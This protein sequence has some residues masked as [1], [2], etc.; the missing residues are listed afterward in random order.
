M[1]II[2]STSSRAGRGLESSL[3]TNRR[4]PEC[5]RGLL[6]IK[7]AGGTAAHHRRKQQVARDGCV[8]SAGAQQEIEMMRATLLPLLSMALLSGNCAASVF[9]F[10]WE[11]SHAAG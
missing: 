1:R 10:N 11:G 5:R 2:L 7:F 9:D 8:E 4:A 3:R 6:N